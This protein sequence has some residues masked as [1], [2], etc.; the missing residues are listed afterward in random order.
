MYSSGGGR[1]SNRNGP[2]ILLVILVI[3]IVVL[4]LFPGIVDLIGR[5]ASSIKSL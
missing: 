2:Y 1:G 3:L 5:I 4:I